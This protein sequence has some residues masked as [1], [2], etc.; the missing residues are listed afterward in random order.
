MDLTI[1]SSG[2]HDS[3]GVQGHA[4]RVMTRPSSSRAFVVQIQRDLDAHLETVSGRV[5]HVLSG[6]S[7][8]F[9]ALEELRDFMA[10]TLLEEESAAPSP[11]GEGKPPPPHRDAC[12]ESPVHFR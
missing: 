5:E 11:E 6:K 8:R 1:S 10:R 7:V 2:F 3:R 4:R 12:G 9:R